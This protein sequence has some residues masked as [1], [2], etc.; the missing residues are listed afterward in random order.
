MK[1]VCPILSHFDDNQDYVVNPSNFVLDDGYK[2]FIYTFLPAV[3][4][5]VSVCCCIEVRSSSVVTAVVLT[6]L[7]FSH[8]PPFVP[9]W[10]E[11]RLSGICVRHLIVLNKVAVIAEQRLRSA[12]C[13]EKSAL[14]GLS[15]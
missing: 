14:P 3:P 5:M 11:S 13:A 10:Q 15:Q 4:N 6:S 12:D 1:W 9:V 8:W 7:L 2:M